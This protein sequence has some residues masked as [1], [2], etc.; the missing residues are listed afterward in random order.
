[1]FATQS[2]TTPFRQTSHYTPTR[3][4]PLGPR[5]SNIATPPWTMG[6]PLTRRT[7][8]PKTSRSTRELLRPD[9]H[10][11]SPSTNI[12]G[13]STPCNFFPAQSNLMSPTSPSPSTRSTKFADRYAAQVANPMKGSA[14]LA[15]SKTRKMFMNRVRNE[16]DEGRFEAR[17]EQMMH[18]DYLADKRKWEAAMARDLDGSIQAEAEEDDMLPDEDTRAFDEYVSQQEA[19]EMA[20]NQ[21]GDQQNCSFSDDEYDD[22]FMSLPEHALSHDN[23]CQDMDMS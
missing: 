1:M 2:P 5:T 23:E 19:M 12:F 11:S 18:A 4:S 8:T 17:G 22:I 16:R 20:L 10:H 3:P 6:S 13:A 14:A 21:T 9:L 7:R 15:R